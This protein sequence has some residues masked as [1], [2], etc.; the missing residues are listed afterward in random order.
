MRV[1]STA[2][3]DQLLE[4]ENKERCEFFSKYSYSSKDF[5]GVVSAFYYFIVFLL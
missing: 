5:I 1:F 3:A 2:E 4:E